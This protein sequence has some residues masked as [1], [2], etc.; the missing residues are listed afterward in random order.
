MCSTGTF[1]RWNSSLLQSWRR[2]TQLNLEGCSYV[3]NFVWEQ[4]GFVTPITL[5]TG[6]IGPSIQVGMIPEG[7]ANVA[8]KMIVANA[9]SLGSG[10]FYPFSCREK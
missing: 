10:L 8:D 2:A 3:T 6:E 5:A 1:Y 7:I 9:G 4:P